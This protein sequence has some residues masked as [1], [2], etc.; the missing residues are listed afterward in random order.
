MTLLI[1]LALIASCG[2]GTSGFA[3]NA[4]AAPSPTP[5]VTASPSPVPTVGPSST[6]TLTVGPQAATATFAP[7][8]NGVT[9]SISLPPTTSGSG[10]MTAVLSVGPPGGV[11][12]IQ[13]RVR[14]PASFGA[15]SITP[16]AYITLTAPSNM[17]FATG[18]T[19]AMA[20]SGP[21][22]QAATPFIYVAIYDP[23][24]AAY[25]WRNAA[26]PGVLTGSTL[27]FSLAF[28]ITIGAGQSYIFGIYSI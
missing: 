5:I 17:S 4:T 16:L 20:L 7:I 27:T 28:S 18:P 12:T 8:A 1:P 6:A 15:S 2:P 21:I 10:L 9:G 23:A 26:G 11:P 3:P 25:G 19:F 22:T 24:N 14:M 13:S